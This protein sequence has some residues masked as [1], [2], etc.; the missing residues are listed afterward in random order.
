MAVMK[1]FVLLLIVL[2]SCGRSLNKDV[3]NAMHQYDEM[4]LHTD[5]KGIAAMFT[6]D[7]EMAAPGMASIYGRDSIQNFLSQ[8]S[9]IKVLVQKS[10]TDSIQWL[11][12]TA[13]QYGT[14]YQRASVNN[15][16]AEVH[17]MFQ[18]NWVTLP[19]GKLLLKRMSAWPIDK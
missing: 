5:T 16:I 3:E 18:A 12:D 2:F 10:N 14:Y 6:A 7:G 1:I 13:I 19:G 17:G 8:F 4:I 15:T 11:G 9:G